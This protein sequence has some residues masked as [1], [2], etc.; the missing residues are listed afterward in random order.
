MEQEPITERKR[1]VVALPEE[2]ERIK[3]RGDFK[4]VSI[5]ANSPWW[6]SRKIQCGLLALIS[7]RHIFQ[8]KAP[9]DPRWTFSFG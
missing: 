9:G 2:A 5:S 6:S 7:F 1:L 3:S 8:S 4:E